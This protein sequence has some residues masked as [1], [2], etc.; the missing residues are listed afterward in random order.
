[1][2]GE[3]FIPFKHNSSLE[4]TGGAL[5]LVSPHTGGQC[6]GVGPLWHSLPTEFSLQRPNHA[7]STNLSTTEGQ[8]VDI[9]RNVPQPNTYFLTVDPGHSPVT[10]SWF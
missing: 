4:V 7:S 9:P 1:M 2:C 10:D 6:C 3:Q 5:P 8:S